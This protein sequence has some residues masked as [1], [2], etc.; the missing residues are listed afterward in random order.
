MLF[1]LLGCIEVNLPPTSTPLPTAPPAFTE[2]CDETTAI[3]YLDQYDPIYNEWLEV[4]AKA[5][6]TGPSDLAPLIERM[7]DLKRR[8]AELDPPCQD[9]ADLQA[10]TVA[11]QS[12]VIEAFQWFQAS[13]PDDPLSPLFDQ[14][15]HT[16]E[17]VRALYAAFS[18][19]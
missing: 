18:P 6:F 13:K 7:E 2:V 14:A 10:A 5:N 16:A 1:F 8:I 17:E 15:H 11:H 19:F 4:Y 9:A 3:A 12:V